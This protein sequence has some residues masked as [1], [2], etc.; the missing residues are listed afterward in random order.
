MKCVLNKW[1]NQVGKERFS[2]KNI[3]F[4]KIRHVH[5]CEEYNGHD[6]QQFLKCQFLPWVSS[7]FE[8]TAERVMKFWIKLV[9]FKTINWEYKQYFKSYLVMED[10]VYTEHI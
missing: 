3:Y 1:E 9:H 8:H 5:L 4:G 10:I 6:F 7:V 2:A